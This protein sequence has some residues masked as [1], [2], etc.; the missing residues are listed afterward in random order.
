MWQEMPLFMLWICPGLYSNW[1]W[2]DFIHSNLISVILEMYKYVIIIIYIVEQNSTL[3]TGQWQHS[4]NC[5]VIFQDF[6]NTPSKILAVHIDELN[7]WHEDK[8]SFQL[9]QWNKNLF[10]QPDKFPSCFTLL[11]LEYSSLLWLY[12]NFKWKNETRIL[13]ARF[14]FMYF[15]FWGLLDTNLICI[16]LCG[17]HHCIDISVMQ[18]R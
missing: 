4:A 15:K 8:F 10:F 13:A 12:F 1:W 5:K 17:M 2:N 11:L 7:K 18:K 16:F 6:R 3:P 9:K 14:V